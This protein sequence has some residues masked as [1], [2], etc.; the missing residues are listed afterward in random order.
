MNP[1]RAVL[2]TAALLAVHSAP[3]AAQDSVVIIRGRAAPPPPALHSGR[4][5]GV[6][7]DFLTPDECQRLLRYR[8]GDLARAASGALASVDLASSVTPDLAHVKSELEHD[9]TASQWIAMRDALK[10]AAD[11]TVTSVQRAF[12]LSTLLAR[13]AGDPKTLGEIVETIAKGS[14]EQA[15]D[16]VVQ[17]KVD[18]YRQRV[19]DA[20]H[21]LDASL[22][23]FLTEAYDLSKLTNLEQAQSEMRVLHDTRIAEIEANIAA[24]RA[25]SNAASRELGPINDELEAIDTTLRQ[26]CQDTDRT[27]RHSTH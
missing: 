12:K 21:D 1:H 10:Y 27:T 2:L 4:L 24:L 15:R 19:N 14:A 9:Y 23:K 26:S 13:P 3:L 11:Q 7:P 25:T 20:A 6:L 16:A 17:G 5:V 22:K 8:D 18:A